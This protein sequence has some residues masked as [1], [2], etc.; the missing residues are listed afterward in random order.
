MLGGR[1]IE[2]A[3]GHVNGE[4]FFL[5]VGAGI[6]A[7]IVRRVEADRKRRDH[8]GGMAQWL[9]PTWREFARRP[10]AD[11]AVTVEGQRLEGLAQVLVTR[12]RSYAGL[13]RMPQGIDMEDGALHVLAF[14]RKAKPLLLATA[15]RAMTGRMRQGKELTHLVTRGPIRI[16]SAGGEEPFHCDGDHGG[17]L[18]V[19]VALVGD[20]VRL[21]VP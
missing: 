20:S 11:L 4:R 19:D 13:M 14:P 3:R 17:E 21:L 16:E 18:P 5:F 12:T 2:A 7:R 6:D 15:L 9:L 8:L 1:T 10:L